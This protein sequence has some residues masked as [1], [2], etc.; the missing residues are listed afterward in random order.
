M[1]LPDVAQAFPVSWLWLIP[2]FPLLGAALNTAFGPA[3]QKRF[4]KRANHAIAIGVMVASCVVAE[5]A[6]WKMFA[7]PAHD[8]F[9]ENRL[10]TMWQS[11]SLKV[12]LSFALDPLGMV[13]TLIVTTSRRSSTSTRS[14]TWPT[15]PPTGGSS[16][17]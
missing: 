15:S 10:W 1:T 13:M 11:G 17:G 16:S 5:I 2:F 7:R 12:D 9:F 6:F 3:L 14:G 8:R 4:G